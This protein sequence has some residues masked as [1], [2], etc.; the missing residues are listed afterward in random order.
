M[1]APCNKNIITNTGTRWMGLR[2]MMMGK[3]SQKSEFPLCDRTEIK[4]Y[5]V[6]TTPQACGLKGRERDRLANGRADT[7]G[8]DTYLCLS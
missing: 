5:Q 2:R 3:R 4:L 8:E 1:M 6:Q 7:L